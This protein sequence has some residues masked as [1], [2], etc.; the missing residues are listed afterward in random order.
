PI[1]T[2]LSIAYTRYYARVPV[3]TDPRPLVSRAL[4]IGTDE[5]LAPAWLT[6]ARMGDGRGATSARPVAIVGDD[7]SGTVTRISAV[8][9]RAQTDLVVA[10]TEPPEVAGLRWVGQASRELMVGGVF[11]DRLQRL[12]ARNDLAGFRYELTRFT[13]WLEASVQDGLVFG[14]MAFATPDEVLDDGTR[15]QQAAANWE[16]I[17]PPTIEVVVAHSLW[18]FAVRLVTGTLPHPWDVSS[19][20]DDLTVTFMAIIGRTVD[21]A[22]LHSA[23]ALQVAYDTA[24]DGLN[25]IESDELLLSYGNVMSGSIR[26]GIVGYRELVEAQQRQRLHIEH[27]LAMREWTEK[28]IGSRDRTLSKMDL[29][30]QLYRKSPFGKFLGLGKLVYQG[31]R[32]D[33]KKVFRKVSGFMHA[34][35]G[36]SPK[37]S[38][39]SQLRTAND[40]LEAERNLLAQSMNAWVEAR[41]VPPTGTILFEA[42]GTDEGPDDD[43]E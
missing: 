25:D 28:I 24:V 33:G 9:G 36:T 32:R 34:R 23:K 13:R 6:I 19:N 29:Q 39:L 26:V 14:P 43:D 8:D 30:L 1:E 18:K 42:G 21:S 7:A 2:A 37:P 27:L 35:R 10:P 11:E 15:F 38:E 17:E 4:R 22:T 20:A 16:P 3:L 40:I 31:L 41:P 12:C 5:W